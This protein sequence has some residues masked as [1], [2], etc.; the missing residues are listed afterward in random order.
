VPYLTDIDRTETLAACALS[1]A[2]PAERA[3]LL[4]CPPPGVRGTAVRNDA[5][6]ASRPAVP[7][8]LKLN[9]GA[10]KAA[11]IGSED[12]PIRCS[13]RRTGTGRFAGVRTSPGKRTRRGL[14]N[15][16]NGPAALAAGP[17]R[18]RDHPPAENH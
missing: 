9:P 16:E 6:T 18:R 11:A 3:K 1:V 5:K 14:R 8:L 15:A 4:C 13:A 10:E 2:G 12:G 7:E 17:F